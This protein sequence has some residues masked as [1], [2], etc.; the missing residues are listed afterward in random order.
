MIAADG[1]V[2]WFKDITSVIS[3]D[4]VPRMLQGVI[5]DITERKISEQKLIDTELRLSTLLENLQN[6]VF[7]ESSTDGT[8]ITEN[9]KDML[10]YT[11]K[12]FSENE[13][14]FFSIIHPDDV[15][16]V[17]N[18]FETWRKPDKN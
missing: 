16:P 6:V 14:L 13:G 9:I 2:K 7:Y 10:G 15:K 12:E 1:T 18:K 4:G 3:D 17:R 5:V 11:S 8:Y